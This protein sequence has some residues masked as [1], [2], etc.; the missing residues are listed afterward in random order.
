MTKDQTLAID[1]TRESSVL[2]VYPHKPLIS[3]KGLYWQG[4]YLSH[5]YQPPHQTPE[6]RPEQYLIS[7]HL[8]QPLTLQQHWKH[9]RATNEFQT[10][11]DINIYPITHSL[12]E[13]WNADAE[14][15]EIYLTPTL[16]STIAYELLDGDR[17]EILP[18]PNIRD[19]LIQ[20]LG[21]SLKRELEDRHIDAL[22]NNKSRLLAESIS[23][24]LTVHLIKT[25]SSQ[26]PV[27]RDYAGGLPKHKLRLAI[28][29]IQTNLATD[30]SLDELSQTIG[31][32]MHHFSRLFKQS[33]GCSPYQHVLRCRVER[34]KRLLLQRK[35][36]IAEVAL[37]V[38]FSG[39]SHLTQH[40][41]RQVGTTPKQFLKQ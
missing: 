26:L 14:Y 38:G 4:I 19:P 2:D 5:Y 36:T 10:Y 9:G 28:D 27:I 34:A 22:E 3:S 41:K 7:I 15:F 18:Q 1:F 11:G 23:S 13:T 20:Q 25:Y 37:A 33:L 30:I 12:K 40:F 8:G 32:S 6:Y 24:V 35:L 17:L 31:M 29:Y 21:L 16:F 39:Q